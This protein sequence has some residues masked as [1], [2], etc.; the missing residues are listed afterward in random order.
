MDKKRILI[1]VLAIV[2][3]IA[4]AML[5]RSETAGKPAGNDSSGS[6]KYNDFAKCL[7]DK[8]VKFYGAY[9]CGHCQAQK[10]AFGDSFKYVNYIECVEGKYG[11]KKVCEDEKITS[12]P[13]WVFPDGT[14][15][16]GEVPME[17]LAELSG[18]KL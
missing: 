1:I 10:A 15:K 7:T 14:R 17:S 2:L 18:C 5:W 16:S 3:V 4:A 12:Y 11:Q 13:T 6:G 8:G 9:W